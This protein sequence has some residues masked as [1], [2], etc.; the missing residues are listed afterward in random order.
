MRQCFL[1]ELVSCFSSKAFSILVGVGH[2]EGV[3]EGWGH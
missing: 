1:I 2:Y 3:S